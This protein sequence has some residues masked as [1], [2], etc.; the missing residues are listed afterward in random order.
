[1][2][3][4]CVWTTPH[5]IGI[6]P[7]VC[8]T[9]LEG[10]SHDGIDFIFPLSLT[11][12]SPGTLVS[13]S[14]DVDRVL[15]NAQ[16]HRRLYETHLGEDRPGVLNTEAGS[17]TGP[18]GGKALLLFVFTTFALARHEHEDASLTFCRRIE[19]AREAMIVGQRGI[20]RQVRHEGVFSLGPV[21]LAIAQRLNERFKLADI[22]NLPDA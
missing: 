6:A 16:L 19:Q 11:G 10:V 21:R 1:M 7:V 9:E 15:K 12:G 18:L 20:G 2:K 3:R 13:F 17:C 5:D 22:P 14:A 8:V 4:S